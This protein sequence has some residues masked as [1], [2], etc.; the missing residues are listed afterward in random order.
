MSPFSLLV[1]LI[2]PSSV[3]KPLQSVWKILGQ[4]EMSPLLLPPVQN[5]RA[6]LASICAKREVNGASHGTGIA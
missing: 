5:P 2:A 4:R 1:T 6:L 3:S